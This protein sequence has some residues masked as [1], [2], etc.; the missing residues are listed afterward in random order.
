MALPY[1]SKFY[2]N[3]SLFDSFG[4]LNEKYI[5]YYVEGDNLYYLLDQNNCQ[6]INLKTEEISFPSII[7][8]TDID[9]N[10]IT[11]KTIVSKNG[12]VYGFDGYQAKLFRDEYV[13][14]KKNTSEIWRENLDHSTK[15]MLLSSATQ[16]RDFV[17]DDDDNFY[18]IHS[19]SKI[20]KFNKFREKIYTLTND[21]A[22]LSSVIPKASFIKLDIIREYTEDGLAFYPILLGHNENER[23]FL[24]KINESA[25]TFESTKLI[26]SYG[27]YEHETSDRRTNY[28]LTNYDYLKHQIKNKNSL[29]FKTRLKNIY[30]N[31]NVLDL[32]IPVDIST[33]KN[34]EHHF[35]FRMNTIKG[36]IDVFVDGALYSSVDFPKA[37]FSFQDITQESFVVGTTYF[38]NNITLPQY[39][40]QPKNYM[41]NNC[42]IKNF[43]LF[44]KAI[45]NDEIKF[46]LINNYGATDL[47]ASLPV[48]HRNEI[49]Q[50]ERIFSVNTP[51]NKSNKINIIIKNSNIN[52]D[53]IKQNVK[54]V[55]LE[56]I[57]KIL[58]VGVTVNEVVFKNTDIK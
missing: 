51:G 33:F 38:Y 55:I 2:S 39:L 10:D 34:G 18:V 17:I 22:S 26:D 42:S 58:P 40:K 35:I 19:S 30:N 13:L 53:I 31:R 5:S 49:E 23:H 52:N 36:K 41:L 45:S 27:I 15:D 3:G 6:S 8:P 25:L 11:C 37:D 12:I 57:N 29:I 1:T 9:G 46:L 48:G 43:K 50:I 44:D 54:N 7:P 47:I 16:I 56:K 14:Y 21:N 32:A 24:T 20:T 28:N 4:S